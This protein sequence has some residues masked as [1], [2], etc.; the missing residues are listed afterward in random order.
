[1]NEVAIKSL[2]IKDFLLQHWIAVIL[3]GLV[4]YLLKNKYG[5]DLN[6]IPGP[7]LAGT[8]LPE[9]ADLEVS[10][11]STNF[12]STKSPSFPPSIDNRVANGLKLPLLCTTNMVRRT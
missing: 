7:F 10:P 5:N 3:G 2:E 12:I 1:M 9:A 11:N 6:G 8:L 4:L